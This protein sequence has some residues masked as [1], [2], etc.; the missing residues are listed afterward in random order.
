MLDTAW[1]AFDRWSIEQISVVGAATEIPGWV[2]NMVIIELIMTGT[3]IIF[4]WTKRGT[5][6]IVVEGLTV[7]PGIDLAVL[8]KMDCILEKMDIDVVTKSILPNHYTWA[9]HFQGC[10]S[11]YLGAP[12]QMVDRR[13]S[14]KCCFCG[15][16][17]APGGFSV[18]HL[19][20]SK[21][22]SCPSI[23]PLNWNY[24][25]A[26]SLWLVH[27]RWQKDRC[28]YC[29]CLCF[30]NFNSPRKQSFD[31]GVWTTLLTEMMQ[32]LQI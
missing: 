31:Y 12:I 26:N 2:H 20:M 17:K 19:F 16:W 22:F 1:H 21:K 32:N 15:Q 5:T 11:Y 10:R 30:K 7:A 29:F 14:Y 27:T 18:R 6:I 3:T 25:A 13:N 28:I 8:E 23:I 4:F 24:C 9:G